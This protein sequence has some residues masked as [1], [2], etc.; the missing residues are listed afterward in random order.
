M[1][2]RPARRTGPDFHALQ[3]MRQIWFGAS[4]R[5]GWSELRPARGRRQRGPHRADGA[6][7]SASRAWPSG[8]PG[9]R[10][11]TSGQT[12]DPRAGR[13]RRSARACSVAIHSSVVRAQPIAAPA[14]FPSSSHSSAV[15]VRNSSR[16]AG[17]QSLID[18]LVAQAHDVE[19]LG[20]PVGDA[21]CLGEPHQVAR[22]GRVELDVLAVLAAE[23]ARAAPV[24][25]ARRMQTASCS[26]M[27]PEMTDEGEHGVEH[28]HLDPLALPG[29]LARDQRHHDAGGAEERAEVGCQREGRVERPRPVPARRLLADADVV[30]ENFRPGVMDRLGLAW[31]RSS[32]R[33]A[34][35]A[36][37][38][39]YSWLR[40]R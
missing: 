11:S 38:L 24:D 40:A 26:R 31:R 30:I 10:P 14:R 8:G 23:R 3:R 12:Q 20:T 35:R 33:S 16:S 28:G 2:A 36:D 5:R 22:A 19:Q 7:L 4:C 34:M 15:R 29:A 27:R 21:R 13:P 32:S 9:T 1:S 37:L 25:A 17:M 18:R 39:L 6:G